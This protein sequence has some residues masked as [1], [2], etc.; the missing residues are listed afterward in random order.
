M[1]VKLKLLN[2]LA[3]IPQY[4][5]TGDACVDLT[6]TSF[7]VKEGFIEYGTGIT[8]EIP[9]GHVGLIFPRSSVTNKPLML[10]NSVGVIDSSYRGEIKFRFQTLVDNHNSI[11]STQRYKVG[12]RIG[13][14]LI[15]P[16]PKVEFITSDALTDTDRGAG[17]Y[18]ST[19]N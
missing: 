11:M 6:A 5:N 14:L 13:Q 8:L 15:L 3:T 7:E 1:Q 4:A 18:G 12:D 17:G 16:F 19:G 2:D 9:D 10:K